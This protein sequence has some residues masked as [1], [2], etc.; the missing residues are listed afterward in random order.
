MRRGFKAEA[1]RLA[2]DLRKEMGKRSSEHVDAADYARHAGAEVRCADELTSLAKLEHLDELQPGAFSACTFS[3][4]GRHIVVYS[5][6]ASPGRTQSDI[7]HEVAHLLL[8]HSVKSV[9][10]IGGVSFFTCDADEEQ[11]ANWLAGCLLL[12]R[13]LL[14]RAA[15][16]GMDA[17]AMAEACNVSETMAVFRLRTTGVER[18]LRASRPR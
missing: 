17:T 3:I 15:K 7:A 10:T 4:G 12:P 18:Q 9:E 13:P 1:E 8:K 14:F 6:L 2:A 11:E 16:R 5:P